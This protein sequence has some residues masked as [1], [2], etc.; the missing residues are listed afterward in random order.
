MSC[1]ATN[2]TSKKWGYGLGA[3]NKNA[4]KSTEILEGLLL[5]WAKLRFVCLSRC[6]VSLRAWIMPG[7]WQFR[8]LWIFKNKTELSQGKIISTELMFSSQFV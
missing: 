7:S 3:R 8:L 2:N 1:I 5:L 4:F 6:F